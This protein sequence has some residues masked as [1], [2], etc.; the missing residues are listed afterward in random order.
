MKW[1]EIREKF[2]R[3]WLLVETTGAR[4]EG[5]RRI[6][7]TLA[8]LASFSDSTDAFNAY[9]QRHRETP[10]REL[11]VLHTDREQL[12]VKERAWMGIRA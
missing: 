8:V 10:D 2:P 11:Y 6:L 12:D 9:K 7:E 4:S 3:Q 1:I 5:D